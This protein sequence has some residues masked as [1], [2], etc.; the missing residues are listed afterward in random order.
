MPCQVLGVR[1]FHKAETEFRLPFASIPV[2]TESET[3]LLA[4]NLRE[5]CC[6]SAPNPVTALWTACTRLKIQIVAGAYF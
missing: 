6:G 5:L 4:R 2:N 1:D 3:P